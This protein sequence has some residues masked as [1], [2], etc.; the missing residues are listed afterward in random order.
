MLKAEV[1]RRTAVR[2][3]FALSTA[4]VALAIVLGAGQSAFAAGPDWP[5]EV[6]ARYRL[7]FNGLDVGTYDFKSRVNGK[8]YSVVGK[9]KITALFGAFKWS[10]HF[11]GSGSIDDGVPHP[12]SFEM[13]YKSSSKTHSVKLGFDGDRI[14]TV[15]VEPKKRLGKNAIPLTPK[16][17]RHVFDPIAATLAV[18]SA[19]GRDA[20][21]RTIPVFDGK[22]RFDLKL[23]LKGHEPV[24]EKHAAEQ[25]T[26]LVVCRV[27]YVPIAGHKPKD[28]VHPWIDYDNIE[29]ALRAVPKA[30]I[31]VPYRVTV[32]LTLGSAVMDVERINITAADDTQIALRR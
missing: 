24:K 32:P 30:G 6:S 9:T 15:A 18:S 10:G 27:K 8:S 14:S 2:G 21:D 20:C 5:N 28:F 19:A 12:A 31:Y 13:S 23:T 1:Y 29:I 4:T 25:T 11:A 17:F 3:L 16:D 7:L 22:I 26:D